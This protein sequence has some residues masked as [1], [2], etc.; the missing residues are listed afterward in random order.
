MKLKFTS[1]A[2]TTAETD[3]GQHMSREAFDQE[4]DRQQELRQ[5]FAREHPQ[6]WARYCRAKG[7]VDAPP[8]RP[9]QTSAP[10]GH[11]PS[12]GHAPREGQN[13]HRRGSRRGDRA[14]S[15]SSDDPDPDPEPRTCEWCGASIEDLNADA[16]HCGGAHRASHHRA[17]KKGE[18]EEVAE[19]R[20]LSGQRAA[21]EV[22]AQRHAL[23]TLT[24]L[25]DRAN[26]AVADRAA[27]DRA[28]VDAAELLARAEEHV[29]REELPTELELCGCDRPMR[30][31]D[32]GGDPCCLWCARFLAAPTGCDRGTSHLRSPLGSLTRRASRA[33]RWGGLLSRLSS[34]PPERRR[35]IT[36]VRNGSGGRSPVNDAGAGGSQRPRKG[37]ERMSS[38]P[39]SV[40][41]PADEPDDGYNPTWTPEKF[42]AT[43]AGTVEGRTTLKFTAHGASATRSRSSSSRP[44][45]ASSST[46]SAAERRSHG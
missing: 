26:G 8:V 10:R 11:A 15:S 18:A 40:P 14:R 16:R 42:P 13:E 32:E 6:E 4:L 20:R 19:D 1:A 23:W 27:L 2:G 36:Y 33:V 21:E 38:S 28:I 7:Y 5:R 35:P 29:G 37:G 25:A 45:T 17:R 22:V 12:R 24:N 34:D 3:S 9:R 41:A 44:R 46:C 31:L 30:Y 39:N 43:I